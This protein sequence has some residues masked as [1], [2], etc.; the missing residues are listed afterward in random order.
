MKTEIVN[1]FMLLEKTF[2]QKD[3]FMVLC[4]HVVFD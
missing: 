2:F 3:A 1:F 4:M